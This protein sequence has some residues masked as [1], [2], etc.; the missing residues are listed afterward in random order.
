MSEEVAVLTTSGKAYYRLVNEL[1]KRKIAFL[2]LKTD[3]NIPHFIKVII[4]TER[5][6]T[7]P[8]SYKTLFYDENEDPIK[9]IDDLVKILHGKK[10]YNKVIIG[11][12]PGKRFG[13]AILGDGIIIKTGSYSNIEKTV[14]VIAQKMNEVNAKKKIVKVGDGAATFGNALIK[15]LHK[16]LPQNIILES[17]KENGTT[18]RNYSSFKHR[19]NIRD[20]IAAVKISSREGQQ[21]KRENYA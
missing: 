19:M 1:K 15:Y 17:V 11:V 21:I 3:E 10:E 7:V 13:F 2:S 14:Q 9:V 16:T 20:E 8:N 4:T 18:S 6:K 12:D 5:K